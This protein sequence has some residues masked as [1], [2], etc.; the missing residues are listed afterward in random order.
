MRE[1][2]IDPRLAALAQVASTPPAAPDESVPATDITVERWLADDGVDATEITVDRW[3]A[4]DGA[5]VEPG[6]E[7]G[8]P[9]TL[10]PVAATTA[11]PVPVPVVA[12]A[13][14][15]L[16]QST[17]LFHAPILLGFPAREVDLHVEELGFRIETERPLGVPWSEVT[18][19]TARRGHV[20]VGAEARTITFAL[21]LDGVAEPTLAAPF[22]RVLTEAKAGDFDPSGTA[23]NDLQNAIDAIRDR[24]HEGDDPVFPVLVGSVTLLL[25]IGFAVVLPDALAIG[26]RATPPGDGFLVASRVSS[27]DPRVLVAAT[28]AAAMLCALAAWAALGRQAGAWAR[29]TLRGWHSER[30]AFVGPARRMLA[31][32]VRYPALGA[33]ALLLGVVAAIPSARTQA[34]VDATGIVT[35]REL[36][37]LDR[38]RS[39]SSVTEL[40]T[41]PAAPGQHAE[42]VAVVIR[43]AD[44]S[45]LNTYDLYV[46]NGTDRQ[47]YEMALAWWE[48]ARP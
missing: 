10:E 35:I 2:A 22:A 26:T 7:L 42:R 44:D 38:H 8:T 3:L 12:G 17:A 1:E 31:L 45:T 21:A 47:M 40:L 36:P 23:F 39:W 19:V 13:S 43:F 25:T 30:T 32:V 37:F 41:I 28:G 48:A 18:A 6:A 15:P 46:R 27:V 34:I 33:A 29:G 5:L 11:G 24:F 16:P 14:E 4:D 9:A 20:V